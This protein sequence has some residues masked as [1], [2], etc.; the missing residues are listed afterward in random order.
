MKMKEFAEQLR[1][2]KQELMK[3]CE[4]EAAANNPGGIGDGGNR[5]KSSGGVGGFRDGSNMN[6]GNRRSSSSIIPTA[7]VAFR[8]A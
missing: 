1:E 4:G 6:K 5:S 2:T 7:A 3:D 8:P